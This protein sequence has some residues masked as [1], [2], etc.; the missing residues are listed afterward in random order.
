MTKVS[1]IVPVYNVEKYLEKCLDSLVNQTLKDIEIIVVNDGTKDNSQEIIDKYTKKYPKKVKGFIKENGGQSSARNYGLEYAKGEYIGFVDS[2]D[3][4]ELDMFEKLYNKAKEDDFD[5]SICNLNFVYEDTDDKKEFSINMN[6][7]L[8]DKESLRKH[9]I[10]I[11][12][13][14]WNKIYKKSLF[15][16]SKLKFK[17]KVWFE[18][19]EFLYKLVPYVKSVGVID[20]YLYNYLQRQGSVTNT[21]DKRLY[22]YVENLNGIVD[23]Y[24]EK[25]FYDYYKKELEYVYVRYLFATFLKRAAKYNDEEFY[26]A[27]DCA[28]ENVSNTFPK[29]RKNKYFYKSLKGIYLLLFNKKIAKL[30]RKIIGGNK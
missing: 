29:F 8:T 20:D 11:Y 18:D 24:K 6:S 17:E 5:I 30:S 4:V 16:T 14:V 15:E 10:N 23:F 27:V 9:M 28:V 19:V 21:F 26:K 7:D 25:D 3:Y 2:D 13:V 12:P 22:N 1:V